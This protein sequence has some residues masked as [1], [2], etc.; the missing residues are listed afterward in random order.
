MAQQI[1][2]ATRSPVMLSGTG[3]QRSET[4]AESKHPYRNLTAG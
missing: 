3:V 1:F 2:Y 4:P